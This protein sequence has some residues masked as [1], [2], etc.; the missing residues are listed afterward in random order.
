MAPGLFAISV[1]VLALQVLQTRILAVQMWHHQTYMVVTMTL[2]GFAAAGSLVTVWPALVRNASRTLPWCGTLFAASTILG[3]LVLSKTADRAVEMTAQGQY[4]ALSVFYSYLLFPYLFGG[5][6]ITIALSTAQNFHRLYFVNLVGSAVGAWIFIGTIT[7]LGAERLLV[8]CA[9]AGPLASLSFLRKTGSATAPPSR[10][11]DLIGVCVALLA[12]AGLFF[13]GQSWLKIEVSTTKIESIMLSKLENAVFLEEYWTP[14][15]RLDL[16]EVPGPDGEKGAINIYQDG[17]A[18]T[19]MLSDDEF[20]KVADFTV[21]TV[22]YVPHFLRA[23]A[24]EPGPKALAIGIGGGID[25]R[26][27]LRRGARSVLGIEINGT[28]V[29]LVGRKYRE[30]NDDI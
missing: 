10:P 14:L 21:N 17:D 19:V 9:A 22:A 26:H 12:C 8:L 2:L 28:T 5:L 16:I 30:F 24:G 25:L 29:D 23:Q 13:Q 11:G 20:A 4:F 15:C 27:A 6:V 1:A 7:A 3:Y 18:I